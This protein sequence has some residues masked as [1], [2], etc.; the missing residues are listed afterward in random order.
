MKFVIQRVSQGCVSI[1]D[2]TKVSIKEGLVILMGIHRDD[3]L[4]LCET[5]INKILNLRIFS[6]EAKLMNRS[7]RDNQG[8]ILLISQFTLLANVKGQ[9][10][11]SFMEAAPPKKAKLIYDHFVKELQKQWPGKV[12]TGEFG[13]TMTVEI[14][15]EGPVTIILD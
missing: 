9:N 8:E 13:A 10:R 3:T 14:V 15:N 2:K 11:P 5:F 12:K 6:D 4:A 1:Q 7:L